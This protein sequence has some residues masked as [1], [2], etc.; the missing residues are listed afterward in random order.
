MV[1]SPTTLKAVVTVLRHHLPKP[2]IIAI[3]NDL[4]H[5]PGNASF[6]ETIEKMLQL[7][8]LEK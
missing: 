5:V 7:V 8:Q 6:R 3:L 4:C 2:K 1:A